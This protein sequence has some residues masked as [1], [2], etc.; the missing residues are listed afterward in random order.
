[1]QIDK[2]IHVYTIDTKNRFGGQNILWKKL[3]CHL[4]EDLITHYVYDPELGDIVKIKDFF[5]FEYPNQQINAGRVFR[6]FSIFD[7]VFYI[8]FNQKK[9]QIYHFHDITWRGLIGNVF[10]VFM[11]CKTIYESVL[12]GSD[13]PQALYNTQ[14]GKVK[15]LMLN[16]FSH[17][18]CISSALKDDYL[19]SKFSNNKVSVINNPVDNRIFYPL[20]EKTSPFNFIGDIQI[21][22]NAKIILFVGSVKARKGFHIL[23]DSF[24]KVLNEYDNL[25]LLVVGPYTIDDNPSIDEKYVDECKSK[26]EKFAVNKFKFLGLITSEEKLS[27]IYRN[28]H[29]FLFPSYEEG[30][31]NVVLEAMASRMKIIASKLPVLEGILVDHE[32]SLLF[33]IGDLENCIECLRFVLTD[34]ENV[35]ESFAQNAL[36]KVNSSFSISNWKYQLENLYLRVLQ[37]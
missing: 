10:A 30:L 24:I 1:M 14:L 31:G 15:S 26:L 8:I 28:S 23:V 36:E 2:I 19:S 7:L 25:Y 6:F 27:N 21:P 3:S 18:L 35:C 34:H 5:N 12:Q 17:I 22:K 32:N 33:N 29:I 20:N 11:G 16:K 9:N 13:T 4:S 37:S